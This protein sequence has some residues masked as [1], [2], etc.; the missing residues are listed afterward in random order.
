MADPTNN[1]Q[2]RKKKTNNR[3]KSPENAKGC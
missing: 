3:I 2:E 1:E